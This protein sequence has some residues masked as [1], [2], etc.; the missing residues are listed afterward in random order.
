MNMRKKKVMLFLPVIVIPFL[1]LGF[2]A[3]G[4]GKGKVDDSV[5]SGGLNLKLPDANLKE[6]QRSDKLSFY[7]R[8]ERDSAKLEEWMRSDPYYK[9]RLAFEDEP[10]SL[11][12]LTEMNASKY[13]QRLKLSPY[14]AKQNPEDEVLK[15]LSLLQ[16][17]LEQTTT[18][19][20]L[21]NEQAMEDGSVSLNGVDKLE[22]MM[23]GMQSND[24]DPQIKQLST[25]M[26][27]IL[28]A[29]HPERVKERMIEQPVSST[30][31]YNRISDRAADDTSVAGFY[32]MDAVNKTV[33]S[34]AIR[35]VV[36]E[37]QELVNGAIVKLRLLQPLFI[38]NFEV[39]AGN[40]VYGVVNLQGERL[41]IE[42]NSIRSGNS[43]YDVKLE[44]YDMDGL[45]GVHIPGAITRDVAKES[46]DNNLQLMDMGTTGSSFKMQAATAGINSIRSLLSRKVKLVKVIVKQNYQLL[47][48]NKDQ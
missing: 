1:T 29:Q 25:V 30:K 22:Q 4:G 40:F 45:Q 5:K 15:K 20:E 47:I 37:Q 12:E 46:A 34:N 3:L 42:I 18:A 13:G 28:D 10:S 21:R 24:E 17:E 33:V 35:A 27:K 16:R 39:P 38:G 32:G 9:D 6:D 26:D 23:Q 41:N 14:E 43:V 11:E 31:F 19:P 36:H 7:D 2:Y 48:K 8:A 44:V